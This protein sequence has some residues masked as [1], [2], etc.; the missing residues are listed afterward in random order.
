ME[1]WRFYGE[2]QNITYS[3][4]KEIVETWNLFPSL[5]VHSRKCKNFHDII[6]NTVVREFKKDD[7]HLN[8]Y[9]GRTGVGTMTRARLLIYYIYETIPLYHYETPDYI[10]SV[11]GNCNSWN[12]DK[13][14]KLFY[15]SIKKTY[16]VWR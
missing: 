11:Y 4:I 15:Y 2:F 7:G 10:L 3:S 16:T 1:W 9:N 13:T 6:G 5:Q 12:Y 14:L 8:H